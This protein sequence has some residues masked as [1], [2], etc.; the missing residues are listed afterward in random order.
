MGFEPS[1]LVA[2]HM[3]H[4]DSR[5]GSVKIRI[6]RDPKDSAEKEMLWG[7]IL[8]FYPDSISDSYQTSWNQKPVSG[9]SLPLYFWDSGGPRMI[10]MTTML[11]R[12]SIKSVVVK[13]KPVRS[14][15][16]LYIK[17]VD[18]YNL[19]ITKAIGWLRRQM[20]P[21]YSNDVN[22]MIRPPERM[23]VI[24]EKG[25]GSEGEG[26]SPGMVEPANILNCVMTG[27]EI[28]YQKFFAD[29]TPKIVN[30]DLV[31]DE[32]PQDETGITF[33]GGGAMRR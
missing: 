24:F 30:V 5:L 12:E 18:D 10:S 33:H 3:T 8:P 20:Y 11:V 28:T 4:N 19:D 7:V 27:C 6:A 29:G 13:S 32:V 31:F 15:N 22:T 2:S 23:R 16:V 21:I 14:G 1:S 17:K 9:G 25:I 26:F